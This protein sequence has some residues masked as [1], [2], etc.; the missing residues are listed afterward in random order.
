MKRIIWTLFILFGI[1]AIGFAQRGDVRVISE[2]GID[3]L[4][5]KRK[6][7]L[8]STH[9]KGYRIQ[10]FFGNDMQAAQKAKS[11]LLTAFPEMSGQVYLTYTQPYYKVRVGNFYSKLEA[12][13][14][15]NEL[16]T[17]FPNVFVISDE[18]DLPPVEK[19]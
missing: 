7:K 2:P 12:Q 8:D 3:E 13:Y 6:S 4:I 19:G 16:K 10:I 17:V 1:H 5:D 18:I 9:L 15:L 11:R 14:L